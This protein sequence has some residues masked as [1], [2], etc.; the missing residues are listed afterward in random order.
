MRGEPRPIQ[1]LAV[2][3]QNDRAGAGGHAHDFGEIHPC[4][5]RAPE[6]W[7]RHAPIHLLIC[8][9]HQDRAGLLH[10]AHGATP[11]IA[12]DGHDGEA[13]PA[14]L[15]VCDVRLNTIAWQGVGQSGQSPG[16]S[17]DNL[18]GDGFPIAQV[19]EGNDDRPP[20][21]E[22]RL[23]SSRVSD[24]RPSLAD[25]F[26]KHAKFRIDSA[27]IGPQPGL[28]RFER[29]RF[30]REIGAQNPDCRGRTGGSLGMGAAAQNLA[31]AARRCGIDRHRQRAQGPIETDISQLGQAHPGY[32]TG[33]GEVR[34]GG[35]AGKH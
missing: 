32:R 24:A 14:A 10:M 16:C 1:P 3:R 25:D 8:R 12:I 26:I 31:Q 27:D 15:Q 33:F 20:V 17:I 23:E 34:Y 35:H 22:H 9:N 5:E 6:G 19:R 2:Q 28:R 18:A 7:R 13:L 29:P 21:G 4:V 11:N 30:A